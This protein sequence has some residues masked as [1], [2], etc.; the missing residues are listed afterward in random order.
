MRSSSFRKR[1]Y[2]NTIVQQKPEY[3]TEKHLEEGA[4]LLDVDLRYAPEV[5]TKQHTTDHVID[6]VGIYMDE[7]G[8][9]LDIP[10]G[11]KVEVFVMEKDDV[12]RLPDKT[13]DGIHII[14]GVAVHKSIQ[15]LLAYNDCYGTDCSVDDD[16]SLSPLAEAIKQRNDGGSKVKAIISFEGQE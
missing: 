1:Y 7:M 8:K 6:L 11:S 9:V 3:L 4:I 15:V 10:A 13:K 14:I 12:K 2:I 16:I 5:T